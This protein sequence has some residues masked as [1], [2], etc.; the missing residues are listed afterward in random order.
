MIKGGGDW[1]FKGPTI[2]QQLAALMGGDTL[3]RSLEVG[4]EPNMRGMSL[5]GPDSRNTPESDPLA[6][7]ERLFGATFREPGEGSVDPKLALRQSA[8]DAVMEDMRSL[9]SRLGSNDKARLDQHFTAVRD[10]EL[11]LARLQEAPLAREACVKPA[12]PV[13][14]PLLEGRVQIEERARVM[15][16]LSAVALACDLT[17]VLSFWYCDPLSNLLHPNAT[18]GHHQLTHDE[19]GDQPQVTEIIMGAQRSL[20]YLIERL[21][22]IPEGESTLLDQCALLATTDVSEGKTHQIDEYPILIAGRAG[23]A[24]KVGHHYR[25]LT[26]EN[27]SHVALSLT[28]ALGVPAASYGLDEAFV[29]SGLSAVEA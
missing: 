23:G 15:A 18:S 14:I 29:D 7:Y 13:E 27:A 8:L 9:K 2:D 20:A 19:P 25:S 24:L 26:K 6:L 4:V 10:L 1:T 16:D 28:R 5:N 3:F 12:Q 21:R 22:E 17:R 11:R